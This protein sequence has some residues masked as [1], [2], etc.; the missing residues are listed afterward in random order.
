MNPNAKLDICQW[1]ARATW[2]EPRRTA[3]GNLPQCYGCKAVN[4]L[5]WCLASVGFLAVGWML[6]I[7]RDI[8]G[9]IE[10]EGP[11]EGLRQYSRA[12]ISMAK[13]NGKSTLVGWPALYHLD[14]EYEPGNRV[15]G[16]ATTRKQA[17]EVFDAAATFATKIPALAGKFEVIASTK[18]IRHRHNLGRYEVR[19]AD[20][21]R[22][23]GAQSSLW[24]CDELHRFRS[25]KELSMREVTERSTRGKR[26]SLGFDITTAGDPSDSM[27]WLEES[28]Y[29][30]GVIAGTIVDKRYYARIYE[31]DQE[32]FSKEPEYWK[33]KEARLA[34][35]PSHEDLGGFIRDEELAADVQK[36]VE[37]PS[38]RRGVVRFTLNLMSES[39]D[40]M[41]T[42]KEWA[43]CG[44]ATRALIGR[45]C[46]AGVDLSSTT[47]LTAL[48]LLFPDP[49]D[50]TYDVL[51]YFWCPKGR[52]NE[53]AKM[54]GPHGPKFRQWVTEKVILTT[55]GNAVDST[56]IDKQLAEAKR[57]FDVVEVDF[58][59]AGARDLAQRLEN[60]G[61][62]RVEIA[63]GVRLSPAIKELQ[64]L[65]LEGKIRHGGNE[66]LAWMAT[67]SKI[68]QDS[69]ENFKLIKALRNIE[70][71]RV[72]GI[73]ALLNALYRAMVTKAN[74][75]SVYEDAATA[76]M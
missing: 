70:A 1:C 20:G 43:V 25:A 75:R 18:T 31:A 37:I 48:V 47:D 60:D 21:D 51:P 36:A 59:P 13:K 26:Q 7:T 58:D 56:A 55:D 33:S 11:N 67:C 66:A 46:F 73:A 12:F 2:C 68:H 44:G 72:D 62:M 15:I 65:I 32:R 63:Q 71:A 39:D 24:F 14:Q 50:G 3:R 74:Q 49:S 8:F 23:D 34:A 22:N 57:D 4:H 42:A 64:K 40:K 9:T 19:S 6:D 41:F 5:K 45:R 35:N 54:L 28:Q 10:L 29:A 17:S 52:V 76:K 16:I 38:R 53:I 30:K 69:G 61:Q 27:A